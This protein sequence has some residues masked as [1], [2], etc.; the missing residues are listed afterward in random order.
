VYNYK[1]QI[2]S[3]EITHPSKSTGTHYVKEVTVKKNGQ[4]VSRGA[5]TKQE[6]DVFT[7]TFP[8]AATADD[9]IEVTAICS[10]GGARTQKYRPGV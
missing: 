4:L 5:Y 3:V 1:A 8:L 2:L 6:G 9:V 10:V 7:Y